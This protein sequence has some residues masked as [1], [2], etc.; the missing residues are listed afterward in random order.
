MR[1][2][3]ARVAKR[4]PPPA[5]KREAQPQKNGGPR[6]NH[7]AQNPT[8]TTRSGSGCARPLGPLGPLECGPSPQDALEFR[9]P[10]TQALLPRE[11]GAVKGNGVLIQPS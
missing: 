5:R 9:R 8:S 2:P 6:P 3:E 4:K 1:A 7:Q 11:K 10:P